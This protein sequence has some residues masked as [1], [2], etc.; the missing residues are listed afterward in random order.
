MSSIVYPQRAYQTA[1]K[2]GDYNV[3]LTKA[4]KALKE[5]PSDSIAH[6]V[7]GLTYTQLKEHNKAIENLLKAKNN[8]L[9][10][11]YVQLN[12]A[13][14]YAVLNQKDDALFELQ[15]A[16]NTG[17]LL[18]SEIESPEFETLK[19]NE[20]F[21]KI[22]KQVYN[23]TFPCKEDAHFRRFDFWVG[24]WEVFAA[25][26]KGP[27]IANSSITLTNG[28]CG[29]LENYRPLGG[30]AG[31]NSIS[32][33]DSAD[34]KWKQNWVAGGS[35]SHYVEPD[36]P[37]DGQMQ[38]IAPSITPQGNP[39]LLRMTYYLNDDKTVR[40]FMESSSDNG[41]TWTAIFNGLYKPKP[42]EKR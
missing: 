13:K 1:L 16:A 25:G 6:Y 31:G 35:V 20:D 17:Q 42:D 21:L 22:K 26:G 36:N 30:R 23:A 18:Y 15:A 32:Y 11:F 24:E 4:N 5:H 10:F 27:K 40:Q 28:D 19:V 41:N 9:N 7:L 8:G 2:N 39:S 34:K 3:V 29:I 38:I 37:T 12:L 14:N 33:Y